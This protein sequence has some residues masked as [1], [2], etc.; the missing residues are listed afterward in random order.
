MKLKSTREIEPLALRTGFS[1]FEL[2]SSVDFSELFK[3]S[4][5]LRPNEKNAIPVDELK[6]L[7]QLAHKKSAKNT[8]FCIE[9]PES[10]TRGQDDTI[11]KLLEEPRQNVHFV[12]LSHNTSQIPQTILSRAQ[13]FHLPSDES[14][15]E[16]PHFSEKTIA[17]AKK[18]LSTPATALPDFVK[19]LPKSKDPR[20]SAL[21]LLDAAISICHKSYFKTGNKAFLKKLKQLLDAHDAISSNGNVKLQLI[22]NLL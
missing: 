11:L 18:Y 20:T 22:A 12:F 21:E 2:P 5:H 8:V 6:K 9:S 4:F 10:I 14:L 3:N 13:L 16:A 15:S 1:I 7:T 19:S 17:L